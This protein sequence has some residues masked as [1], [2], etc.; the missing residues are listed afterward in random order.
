MTIEKQYNPHVVVV[1]ATNAMVA[2]E[3]PHIE[4]A[5]DKYNEIV[6]THPR[7]VVLAKVVRAH[8]EG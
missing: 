1:W 6:Q 4:D 3:F 7:K 2:Q 8:G 5:E